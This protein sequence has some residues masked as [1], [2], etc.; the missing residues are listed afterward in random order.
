MIELELRDL[1]REKKRWVGP[2]PSQKQKQKIKQWKLKKGRDKKKLEA[3]DKRRRAREAKLFGYKHAK[4]DG[5]F[6]EPEQLMAYLIEHNI[7]KKLEPASLDDFIG[8]DD[9][10]RHILEHE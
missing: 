3:T 2:Y 9:P 5:K 6:R 1:S 4:P 10:L 8:G 7:L